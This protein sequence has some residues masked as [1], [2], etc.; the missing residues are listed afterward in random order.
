V[1]RPGRPGGRDGRYRGA[2]GVRDRHVGRR[3]VQQFLDSVR[4][5]QSVLAALT[6]LSITVWLSNTHKRFGFTL[7]PTIF[8]LIMTMWALSRL[9]L[10]NFRNAQGID[11]AFMNGL[12][13]ASLIV[14][15][16]YLA[17]KSMHQLRREPG[18]DLRDPLINCW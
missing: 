8:V 7:V 5:L 11:M 2:S 16:I 14:L 9:S 18:A 15:A 12:A 3:A 13:S 17:S 1:E 4:R 10:T 6:L